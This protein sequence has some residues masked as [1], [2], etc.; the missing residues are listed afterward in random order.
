MKISVFGLGY[1]GC[2]SVGCLAKE[3]HQVTGVDISKVKVDLI[4]SGQ[5]TIIENDIA[6]LIE[7]GKKNNLISATGDFEKAVYD[8]DV[9]IICVGTPNDEFGRL[10]M[11]YIY[12]VA[13]QIGEA[14]KKKNS[15]HT[16][17]I[18]S[19]VMPGT[20][21]KVSEIIAEHSGKKA[22]QDFCVVSNPEFLREGSAVYD[23]F[24]PPMV[25]VGSDSEKGIEVLREVN[26]SIKAPFE[27]V[28][29][30]IAEMFKFVNNTFH[31]LKV[32]F[33][34][35]VGSIGKGLGVNSVKLMELF[36]KDTKLNISPA[37]LRPGFAYGGSCLPKDLKALKTIA[38]DKFI[39]V[40]VIENI[41]RSNGHHIDRLFNAVAKSGY[42]KIGVLG[43]SFKEGTDDLRESPVITLIEKLVGKGFQIAIYDK[44]VNLANLMG[45]NK[46]FIMQHLPH[47]GKLLYTSVD[48]LI[49]DSELIIINGKD[50]EFFEKI[51][52][53][54]QKPVIDL[55]YLKNLQNRE[56][57]TGMCW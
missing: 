15:F 31:A 8:T 50:A 19:T 22:G 44:N 47:I 4:N 55:L 41:D 28:E 57:Y 25:V 6:E 3:G 10:S 20:N 27:V 24:N 49:A 37:Y 34:N 39:D 43:I 26:K 56:Q 14:V 46:E 13:E 54:P 21:K 53:V 33:A 30:E 5:P 42:T 16:V 29:I 18:R 9:S 48:D 17:T 7:A 1:V 32:A 35:E 2:V 52:K 36:C 23:Y 11:K 12:K 51:E 40:P 38:R 45:A